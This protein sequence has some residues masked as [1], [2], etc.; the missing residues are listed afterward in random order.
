MLGS[1]IRSPIAA[2]DATETEREPARPSPVIAVQL[3][4]VRRASCDAAVVQAPLLRSFPGSAL[5]V[6]QSRSS[7]QLMSLLAA[8]GPPAPKPRPSVRSSPASLLNEATTALLQQA[9]ALGGVL[10]NAAGV[11][12]ALRGDLAEAVRLFAAAA[13]TH[14]PAA[15]FNLGLC[16]EHARGMPASTAKAAR[17][18]ELAAVR[19]HAGACL[20]LAALLMSGT[21]RAHTKTSLRAARCEYSQ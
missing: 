17:C 11:E 10:S 12:T 14:L 18:Y 6:L 8:A 7:G 1:A 21:A 13:A 15:L 3:R 16:H 20:N 5:R 4:D 9:R 19:G 2:L